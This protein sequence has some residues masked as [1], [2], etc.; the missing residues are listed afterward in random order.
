M[1]LL[2][3]I[4]GGDIVSQKFSASIENKETFGGPK[5][6]KGFKFVWLHFRFS[7]GARMGAL[8][9]LAHGRIM[10]LNLETSLESSG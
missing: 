2:S 3:Y 7:S 9:L 8:T 6:N 1:Q 4:V 10:Q 5:S